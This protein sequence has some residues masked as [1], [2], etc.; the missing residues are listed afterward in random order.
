MSLVNKPTHTLETCRY[1]GSNRVTSL[2]MT[3]NDGSL[4][5]FASC[6]RCEGKSWNHAGGPLP[7]ASVLERA[8]KVP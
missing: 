8:R 4:V 7:L 6:H 1:C 5:D 3:L 2:T